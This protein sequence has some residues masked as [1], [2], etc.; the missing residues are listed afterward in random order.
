M[1]GAKRGSLKKQYFINCLRKIHDSNSNNNNNIV[2]RQSSTNPCVT[3]AI[4][5]S[6]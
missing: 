6:K 2:Y 3:I 1:L 4:S 5:E